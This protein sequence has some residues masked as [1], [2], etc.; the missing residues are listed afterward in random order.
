MGRIKGAKYRFDLHFLTWYFSK[1]IDLWQTSLVAQSV[2]DSACNVRDLGLIP[3][4]GRSPRGGQPILVFLSGESRRTEE[5][6]GLQ[7]M[8]LQ[9]VRHASGP[10]WSEARL[11]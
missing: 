3:G 4:S 6:G 2:K 1:P 9:G 5:P 8:G 7:F 11:L 10:F